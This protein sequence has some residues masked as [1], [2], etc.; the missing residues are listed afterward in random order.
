MARQ[1]VYHGSDPRHVSLV[2]LPDAVV[3]TLS[4][5][6]DVM[7]TFALMGVPN[8][9]AGARVWTTISRSPTPWRR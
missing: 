7:N 3:S 8:A 2:A 4:G 6:Y 9:S 5:I 1:S